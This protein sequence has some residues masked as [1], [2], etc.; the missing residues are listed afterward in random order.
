MKIYMQNFDVAKPSVKRVS[1]PTN[2]EAYAIGVKVLENGKDMHLPED[3]VTMLYGGEVLSADG[4]FNGYNV[5]NFSSN[6]VEDDKVATVKV[7]AKAHYVDALVE[8]TS[9][10]PTST[11]IWN[12]T[13]V[14][15]LSSLAGLTMTEPTQCYGA[16]Y[17]YDTD[18]N[19]VS[20]YINDGG[21]NQSFGPSTLDGYFL[22]VNPQHEL[23]YIRQLGLS[24]DYGI[25]KKQNGYDTEVEKLDYF[26]FPDAE[27]LNSVLAIRGSIT[28]VPAGYK[29]KFRQYYT[30]KDVNADFDLYI[31]ECNSSIGEIADQPKFTKSI[32]LNGVYSDDTTF[33]YTIP[34]FGE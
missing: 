20:T 23:K 11:I 25:W 32:E 27:Q 14:P 12:N 34:A 7:N 13:E 19:L 2:T 28:G 31:D 17:I 8:K 4:T 3:E 29:V 15:N 9:P 16:F 6:D 24:V 33:S 10:G 22:A 26:T 5:F 30:G 1:V 21:M 18:D